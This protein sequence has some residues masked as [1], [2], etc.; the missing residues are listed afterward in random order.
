ME[1]SI[2]NELQQIKWIL[3]ALSICVFLVIAFFV[4]ATA[5]RVR[6][7]NTQAMVQLRDGYL[8]ELSLLDSQG[9]Y[10]ELLAKSEEMLGYYPNDLLANWFNAIANK[11]LGQYGAALSAFGRIKQINSSWSSEMVD[12]LVQE[13]RQAMGGPRADESG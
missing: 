11:Q 8:A 13:T 2:L 9:N 5:L 12:D 4:F 6:R 10:E 1:S 3:F 7:S